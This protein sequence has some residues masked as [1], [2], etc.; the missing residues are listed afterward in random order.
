MEPTSESTDIQEA[1]AKPLDLSSEP[2]LQG[3][4]KST[5][6]S[7][8]SI[9][10][11]GRA[12]QDM[13]DLKG[14]M[15]SIRTL[16]LLSLPVVRV[17]PTTKKYHLVAGER[18]YRACLMLGWTSI[19]V[20]LKENYS[21]KLAAMAE[22]EENLR[23]KD[24]TWPEELRGLQALHE[25]RV[26]E[27]GQGGPGLSTGWTEKQTAAVVSETAVSVNRKLKL[28][29]L[30]TERP[31]IAQKI[32]HLDITVAMKKADQLVSNEQTL[33]KVESGE[34]TGTGTILL[35]DCLELIKNIP[36]NSIDLILTDPPFGLS[37]VDN[38]LG[39]ARGVSQSYTAFL[40][41]SDNS[42]IEGAK[43]LL[44]ALIPELSR[45]L[46]PSGH[47]YMFCSFELYPFLISEL[48]KSGFQV[49]WQ[50]LI[51]DKTKTTVRFT[52]LEYPS[53]YEP[54]IFA[55]KPP[56]TKHLTN[57]K[58]KN[59]ISIPALHS[60]KKVHPFQKPNELIAQ[61]INNSSKPGDRVL[62]PF[63]GSGVVI[64]MSQELHREGLGFELDKTNWA[65]AT[66]FV[67]MGSE[68]VIGK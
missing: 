18:R 59:I 47:F 46:R 24:M 32:L 61:L 55:H 63:A 67:A 33:A 58:S 42:T 7:M 10:V 11:T 36:D 37:E 43:T 44:A 35:G 8:T 13:G 3:Q 62:D 48:A 6:L 30:I 49:S 5:E 23:R 57:E 56:R 39:D 28:Q 50:P 38:M 9:V 66:A 14:L 12:R 26:S 45:V 52:G 40:T 4:T 25:A 60:S 41:S 16:G 31:D 19:K 65:K 64:R 54:I 68:S 1:P 29:K 34:I 17:E 2:T 27:H 53:S 51:W 15:E 22:L 21:P 20:I